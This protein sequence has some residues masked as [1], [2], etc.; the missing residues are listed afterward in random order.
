MCVKM[1]E[2][3]VSDCVCSGTCAGV[4]SDC[5]CSGTCAGVVSAGV[6]IRVKGAG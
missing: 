2:C 4:V 1:P 5:V 6:C 3:E